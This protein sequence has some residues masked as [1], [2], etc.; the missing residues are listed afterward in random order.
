[1]SIPV[2]PTVKAVMTFSKF[3]ALPP[4]DQFYTPVS[5]PRH[6]SAGVEDGE[7]DTRTS[8]SRRS[9]ST[10][11]WLKLKATKKSSQRRLK[12]EQAQMVDPFAIP[13]GYKWTSNSD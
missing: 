9:F 12:K 10:P 4:M 5:S 2:I 1:M 8:T 13:A 6:I 7:S 11:S 3:V